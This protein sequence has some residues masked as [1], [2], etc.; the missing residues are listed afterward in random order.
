MDFRSLQLFQH[1]ADT[2]HFARTA[3]A[4][5][6]SPS[7]LS[8]VIQRLEEECGASLLIRDNRSVV[9]TS[10]GQKMRQFCQ[11]TLES[12]HQLQ[13]DIDE[14]NKLLKG[15]L[16]L[17]CS[18]T[19]SFS[20]L[21]D[22]LTRFRQQYPQI[23]IKLTTGEA[24]LALS[25]VIEKKADM[26][27]AVNTPDFPS[28]LHFVPL[29]RI[30]LVMI[31]PVSSAITQLSQL[32]WRK[33]SMVLPE[34][35]PSKR[36]VHHWL[37]EHG[38]RPSVYAKVAGHEAIVSMVALGCGIGIVPKVVVDNIQARVNVI[39]LNDIESFELGL[40]CLKS[41]VSTPVISA[42]LDGAFNP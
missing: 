39:P 18:V 31:T 36:I 10:A 19:A 21:P 25:E 14:D 7:T 4:M 16:R 34:G 17:F 11:T 38:I 3:E 42:L 30:P 13:S 5:F 37:T 15:E 2:L 27:I 26:S 12:W 24:G 29:D 9:L 41:Q 33:E 23:E 20:H 1:L 40:C 28:E 32:D 6:V 8:R 22:L 35:G